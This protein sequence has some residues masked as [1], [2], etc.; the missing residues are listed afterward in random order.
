MGCRLQ[1]GVLMVLAMLFL[2]TT[3][4]AQAIP[5]S[6]QPGR[7]RERFNQP[8]APLA[9]PG[10]EVISLP[11]TTAP[12]GAENISLFISSFEIVGSTVYSPEDL[13]ALYQ[14]MV[15]HEGSL[16]SV[17]DLA[18]RVTARY[19]NDGYVLSRAIVPPQQLNPKGA[20]VRVQ[21]IEGYVDRVEWPQQLTRYRDFFSAYAAKITAQR[22]INIRT[23]ER[24]MLLAGDL[25]GLKFT[26]TLR[27]SGQD[28]GA[29]TLVVD[30]AEKPIDA[31]A[32]VDNRGTPARGPFEYYGSATANNL[33]GW[34]EALSLT[35]AGVVPLQ[36][37]NYA[38]AYYKQ[39]LN[40]EG[41]A[42]FADFSDAWGTPGT[43]QLE[44]LQY[45]TLGPYLDAGLAY[46]F[47][48]SRE[49]NLK[50]SGLF[51]GS[52]SESDVSGARF[53]DD[54]L[55]GF[56]LRADADFADSLL[57]IN[58][59][60][61]IVSQGIQGLGS[62]ENGNPL[63]SRAAGRVDFTKLEI[64]ASRVQPL[65]A[66][67]SAYGALYGQYAATPLL[68]PEQC[69]FGGRFFGRAFD[70]S[71][72]LGDSCVEASG[73]FRFDVP[74]LPQQI[75]QAEIYAFTDWGHLTTLDAA[76]GT[77]ADVDAASA[78]AGVR[79]GLLNYFD[80]D[81]SVA[82]AIEGPRDDWRFFFIVAARY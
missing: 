63:A 71:E 48:R 15:G 40:S 38:A 64:F 1:A 21:V 39:V 69:G 50:F 74:G 52:D 56:R 17:Y 73:E 43:E 19:G 76:V 62:T 49:M 8:P 24:Y 14:G 32:H 12:P 41:L 42:V 20:A 57:G 47:I 58:Q 45:R 2:T 60:Y 51:F 70:P 11:S 82:K 7:E 37:L 78:G 55:R 27:P 77:P 23:I 46:P 26:T 35:Y 65:F 36:E 5:P 75:S 30:V 6:E 72:I 4:G 31:N 10:G 68:V 34:H 61:T 81:L 53:N 80:T 59:L 13:S 44:S 25:P 79:L 67:F 28:T 9:Q 33:L 18:Q 22:P 66:N 29:A 16:K 54:R 3:A